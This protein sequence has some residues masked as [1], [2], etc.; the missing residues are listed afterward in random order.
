[1]KKTALRRI[2]IWVLAAAA[3]IGGI[4]Y[5]S[6]HHNKTA[7]SVYP[8][9]SLAQE[10]WSSGDNYG[11]LLPGTA[12][13]YT[14]SE[15]VV[16]EV[17]VHQGDAVNAGDALFAYDTASLKLEQDIACNNWQIA[18]LQEKK[19][20]ETLAKVRSYIPYQPITP[21]QEERIQERVPADD[22]QA[23]DLTQTTFFI[24]RQTVVYLE[25]LRQL[26]HS[27]VP[28]DP[29]AADVPV[30]AF[31]VYAPDGDGNDTLIGTIAI[32]C[33]PAHDAALTAYVEAKRPWSSWLPGNIFTVA[34]D[35]TVL[36][37]EDA[38]QDCASFALISASGEKVPPATV[39][40][41]ER[42]Y[43]QEQIDQLILQAKMEV[44]TAK[45]TVLQKK[46]DYDR[47]AAQGG[48][49]VVRAGLAGT[50]TTLQDYAS[51]ASGDT[52]LTVSSGDAYLVQTTVGEMQRDTLQLGD[53]LTVT[54]LMT[55]N[56]YEATITFIG[57]TPY[58]SQNYYSSSQDP[59][60]TSYLIRASIPAG[61]DIDLAMESW[62]QITFPGDTASG[63][64]LPEM[65]VRRQDGASYVYKM[66][67]NGTLVKQP[68]KTGRSLY[69][70]QIMILDGLSRDDYIAFP[71][72]KQVAEG[73]RCQQKEDTSELYGY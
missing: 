69:G 66:G 6:A 13:T 67:E 28:A 52:F 10:D 51:L 71:Y 11:Q 62:I 27:Q 18:V 57:D 5:Y 70:Y 39:V 2:L 20:E 44:N 23:D 21:H 63:Y 40:P 68:V 30:L 22:G 35:G 56:T 45:V 16:T 49:G 58:D 1:M 9:A 55:G 42:S 4:W 64:Y 31:N 65:M 7:V 61:A 48:D 43:T 25:Y 41:E 8:V 19:A 17:Y 15:A 53:T 12:E 26:V 73:A 24:D 50:V 36:V 34:E 14:K 60:S 54:A 37:D 3:V 47:I 38:A 46:L 32:P 59:N 33:D 29:E 72:G